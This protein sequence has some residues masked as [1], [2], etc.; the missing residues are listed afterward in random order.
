MREV[1]RTA[2]L[3]ELIKNI[4]PAD[5][6]GVVTKRSKKFKILKAYLDED[7]RNWYGW[8]MYTGLEFEINLQYV[9]T[10]FENGNTAVFMPEIQVHAPKGSFKGLGEEIKA[11]AMKVMKVS[12]DPVKIAVS[13]VIEEPFVRMR[14]GQS[15]D[16]RVVE[17]FTYWRFVDE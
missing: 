12:L 7:G 6:Y 17:E 8:D 1:F 4:R 16:G 11:I 14:S 9:L 5:C 13:E 15:I 10:G 3:D 2:K